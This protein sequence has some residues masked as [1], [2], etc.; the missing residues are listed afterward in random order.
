MSIP[1]PAS[2]LDS[3]WRIPA[4]QPLRWLYVDMNSYF[5][6]VEQQE[7]R[8]LRGRP[9]IVVPLM[10]DWTC[11]IAASYEAKA[12]GIRTGTQVGEAKR[13]CPDVRIVEARHD[14]YV[15][16]HHRILKALE[17]CL[18][19]SRVCSIDEVACALIGHE[20]EPEAATEIAER[21]KRTL[22]ERVG[23][24]IR[25]SI[26]IAPSCL[27]AK[28]AS[29]MQKPNGLTILESAA[30]PGRLLSLKLRDLPGIGANMERRLAAAGVSDIAALWALSPR[31]AR[32]AWGSVEGERFCLG[33]HG[34]DPPDR[35]TERRS[36]GH[37][38]VL[39]PALR[40]HDAARLIARRLLAK[41][42]SRLRRMDLCAG[43]LIV[44]VRFDRADRW[45]DEARLTHT[46]DS[47]A[48]LER[49]DQLWAGLPRRAPPVKKV[50]VVLCDLL[51]E[52]QLPLDLFTRQERGPRALAHETLF[53]SL[54]KLN[55]KYGKDT[56][57]IGA[58]P[59][60]VTDYVGVKIAF[61][62]IPELAEFDE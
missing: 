12:F 34:V 57:T 38:H 3:A 14:V 62:R 13:L 41:A 19:V 46:A 17:D 48:L 32:A 27:L 54:D 8:A 53:K 29:D 25:C 37:S 21:I 15:D 33:L 50:G 5:A 26:G 45:S 40:S 16:Y 28:I 52:D 31:A 59:K 7:R 58:M 4:S 23:A 49:L 11:A 2:L 35:Q 47:F 9:L 61:T 20:R 42:A 18:P 56:V 39:P 55:R 24:H 51:P 1:R 22:N 36:I 30:L 43:R 44:G 10:S 60:T 6:S